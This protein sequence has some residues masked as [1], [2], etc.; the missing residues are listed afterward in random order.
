[1]SLAGR[2]L[3]DLIAYL[4]AAMPMMRD[5]SSTVAQEVELARTYLDIVK[6]R[7]G[8]RLTFDTHV[9]PGLEYARMPPMMLLPLVDHAIVHGLERSRADGTLRIAIEVVERRLRLR[10]V[11]S[12]AGFIPDT[13]GDGIG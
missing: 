6:I 10:I 4:R 12:G 5:T 13:C 8:N 2:M 9:P 11:D 7:L 3:D 1:P